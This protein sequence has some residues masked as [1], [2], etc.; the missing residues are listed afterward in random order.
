MTDGETTR[1]T[2]PLVTRQGRGCL[3]F[4]L[5]IGALSGSRT[6]IRGWKGVAAPR[7][8]GPTNITVTAIDDSLHERPFPRGHSS[9]PEPAM[10]VCRH[11]DFV[12]S[13][14]S[15]LVVPVDGYRRS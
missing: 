11:M 13:K 8:K 14:N 6:R 4:V 10:V 3:P 12:P 7:S 9:T 1:R 15:V 2:G 5:K